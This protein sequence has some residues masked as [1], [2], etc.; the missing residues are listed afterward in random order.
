[1]SREYYSMQAL[2]DTSETNCQEK[3]GALKYPLQNHERRAPPISSCS[4]V[5]PGSRLDR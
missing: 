1:M 5:Q 3:K 2:I 4:A